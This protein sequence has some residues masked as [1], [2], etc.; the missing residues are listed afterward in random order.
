[1]TIK[2]ACVIGWPVAHSRSPL[3]HGYWLGKYGILGSYEREPVRP[4]QV[5]E[6][7]EN[8]EVNGYLGCNVTL[9]HKKTAYEAVNIADDATRQLGVVNTIFMRD[10]LAWGTSTDGEGFLANIE[11]T[12]PGWSVRGKHV[13]LLGAGGAARAIAGTLIAR[14]ASQ[15]SVANRTPQRAQALKTDFGK[16][17]VPVGWALGADALAEA[18]LLV[19]TTSL[20]MTGQPL[21]ELNLGRLRPQT[22]VSDI[23]YVPLETDLLQQ[24][25]ERGNIVV[26]GLGML[27]HQAVRGFELWFGV[28]PE[29]TQ[30]L[31]DFIAENIERRS[32]H[33]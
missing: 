17:I 11:A 20:G 5:R 27:L 6:F 12:V 25:R 18:D 4:Q 3:I 10:D 30:D 13:L 8:L 22:I 7:I 31:H 16:H 2:R 26:G 1:M 19:N 9:P 24:A 15:I 29:V 33:K 23:V 14:G 28:R 21:L 32:A